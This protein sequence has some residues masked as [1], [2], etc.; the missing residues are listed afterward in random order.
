MRKPSTAGRR[1][2]GGA[3]GPC[4]ARTSG[5]A[6]APSGRAGRQEDA[7]ARRGAGA[8]GGTR[9][10]GSDPG[11]GR[12]AGIFRGWREYAR[13]SACGDARILVGLSGRAAL[14]ACR[15][16]GLPARASKCP[17]QGSSGPSPVAEPA[18]QGLSLLQ[19]TVSPKLSATGHQRVSSELCPCITKNIAL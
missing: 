10:A 8:A 13:M 15:L 18:F 1:G 16:V 17:A 2:A 19:T 9:A 14:S 3:P 4:S 6:M 7:G 11:G 12:L 5:W